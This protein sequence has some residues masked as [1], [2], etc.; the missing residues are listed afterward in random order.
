MSLI[1]W[2]RL[3]GYD[4]KC[5]GNDRAANVRLAVAAYYQGKGKG[6]IKRLFGQSL[7][8]LALA[9]VPMAIAAMPA[10]ATPVPGSSVHFYSSC[11]EIRR[12]LVKVP[13]GDYLLYNNGNLFTVYCAGMSTNMPREYIDLAN[14]ASGANF[15]Q[16][17]AGGAS[18][19]TSVRT[20]FTKLRINPASLTV[21]I[22]DLAFASSTGSLRQGSATV[23]SMPYGVAMSCIAPRAANGIGNIDLRSTP[24]QVG[25]TF[26]VGGYL[27][28]GSATVSSDNQLVSLAGGGYCG[29]IAPSHSPQLYNP[30]NPQPGMYDLT[31]SCASGRVTT[32]P[33]QICFRIDSLAGLTKRA[34]RGSAVDL[35]YHGKPIAVTNR[36]GQVEAP[37]GLSSAVAPL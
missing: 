20:T 2:L 12:H 14:T 1:Y 18:P 22:G 30:Y 10:Q 25:S 24:F 8:I 28:T 23:T 27:P 34:G 29:W 19:G 36:A 35:L 3:H 37:A 6:V 7:P 33:G 16:F 17:T 11:G 4:G 32:A 31:L 9:V 26:T 13:D 21:D 5:V 15:S